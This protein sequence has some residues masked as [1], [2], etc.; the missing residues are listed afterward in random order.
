M[1]IV[2]NRELGPGGAMVRNP[3]AD[4]GDAGLIRVGK[5][6]WRRKWQSTPVLLPEE[7]HGQKSLAGYSPGSCKQLDTTE[8]LSAHAHTLYAYGFMCA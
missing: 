4:A 8:Q 5:M 2:R 7:L 3:P 1:R 6:P